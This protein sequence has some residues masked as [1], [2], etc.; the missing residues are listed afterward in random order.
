MHNAHENHPSVKMIR[1]FDRG[2]WPAIVELVAPNARAYVGSME[3]DRDGWRAM[4]EMFR[5][6]F[7]DCQH[8]IVATHVAGEYATVVCTFRGTHKGA[9]MGIPATG[10]KVSFG[11]IHVDLVVDGRIVEHRGELDSAGLMQ[12]LSSA[13]PATDPTA[14]ATEIFRRIDSQKF[15]HAAELMSPTLTFSFGGMKLSRDEWAAFSRG[16]Y[17]AFP[18][19]KHVTSEMLVSGDRVTCIGTFTGTHK[20]EFQGMPATGKSIALGYIGVLRIA[21]G[22]GTE[23]LVQVD[24]AGLIQQLTA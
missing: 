1:S 8:E 22:K 2:D 15:E 20:G 18:D 6:A 7:P 23:M 16:W 3:A 21:G 9:F 11:V 13:A 10:R 5:A 12:Q 14:L 24:S 4:G 19:G 17:A